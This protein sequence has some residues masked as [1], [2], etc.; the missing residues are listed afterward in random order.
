MFVDQLEE[1]EN[2]LQRDLGLLKAETLEDL[3]AMVAKR[4][5]KNWNTSLNRTAEYFAW[6]AATRDSWESMATRSAD[7]VE[8]WKSHGMETAWRFLSGAAKEV[9]LNGWVR[10]W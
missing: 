8:R 1:Q 6:N 5:S 2:M 7:G 10:A 9:E 4:I 3:G